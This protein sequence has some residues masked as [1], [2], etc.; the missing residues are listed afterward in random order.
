MGPDPAIQCVSVAVGQQPEGPYRDD[1]TGPLICEKDQ[2]G[3]IDAHPLITSDGQRYLYWKNDGNAVGVDTYISAAALN[4]DGTEL[5]GKPKRLFKQDLPWEGSLVEG[6][7][8]W[9][10]GRPIPYVLLGQRLRLRRV[11][12]RPRGRRHPLGPYTKSGDPVL[13]TNDVAAGPGHCSLFAHNGRVWMVYHAWT[14]GE[15]GGD[16]PGRAMWLSEVTFAADG[17]VS[18]VPPTTDYPTSPSPSTWRLAL[19]IQSDMT[20]IQPQFRCWQLRGRAEQPVPG[21]DAE[22]GLPGTSAVPGRTDPA[23]RGW[24]WRE[25]EPARADGCDAGSVRPGTERGRARR[26]DGCDA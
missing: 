12:R 21:G 1:S 25:P 18:V 20:C 19:R 4:A 5:V 26:T 10:N 8:V 22:R 11:R 23:E 7:F 14:P 15:I 16:L 2:G 24:A 17:T 9:E 3:S 13:A 6:P